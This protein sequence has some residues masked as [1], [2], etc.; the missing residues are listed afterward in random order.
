MKIRTQRIPIVGDKLV[1]GTGKRYDWNDVH[2]RNLPWTIDGIV[3]DIIVN[4]HALPSRMTIAHLF[5]TLAGKTAALS[6]KFV[7]A[8]PF[9]GLTIED[10]AKAQ[11]IWV[12]VAWE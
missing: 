9:T 2:A 12:S 4:P 1:R 11:N 7:D 10:I 5:E 8:S 3:P 6:G